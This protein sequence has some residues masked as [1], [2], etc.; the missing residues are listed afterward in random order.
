MNGTSGFQEVRSSSPHHQRI[1]SCTSTKRASIRVNHKIVLLC[2]SIAILFSGCSSF[3]STL[4]YRPEF[5]TTFT[6]TPAC[7]PDSL[8]KFPAK[9]PE[10]PATEAVCLEYYNAVKWGEEVA[11]AYRTKAFMNEWSVYI[12]GAVGIIGIAVVGSLTATDEGN[13][14]AAKIIPFVTAAVASLFALNQSDDK[15][16]AYG[17]SIIAIEESLA[18]ADRHV[19]YNKTQEGF[20]RGSDILKDSIRQEIVNLDIRMVA[21]RKKAA[22]SIP[23]TTALVPESFKGPD[24]TPA[25]APTNKAAAKATAQQQLSFAIFTKNLEADQESI[26][27][28]I[29]PTTAM[30]TEVKSDRVI[31]MLT[32]PKCQDYLVI[33]SV[34]NKLVLPA[35]NLRCEK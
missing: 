31:I 28:I 15:A 3:S 27:A 35:R 11:Q 32:N 19:S 24:Q 26:R 9:E 21:I 10:V 1:G 17:E 16:T 20:S 12:A 23:T 29:V 30:T 18:A 34:K 5:S 33:L 25:K 13:T 8:K 4:G 2:L 22:A 14:D 6:S 7:N